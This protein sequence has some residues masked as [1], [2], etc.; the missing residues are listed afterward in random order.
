MDYQIAWL[1]RCLQLQPGDVVATGTHHDGI[2]P[3]NSGETL[4]IEIEKLGR[5]KFFLKGDS[6]RKD[7]QHVAGK[8]LPPKPGMTWP[9]P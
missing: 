7:V 4:E 1:S 3:V 6:P 9:E 5:T 2:G 8:N